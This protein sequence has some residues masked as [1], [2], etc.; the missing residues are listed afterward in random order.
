MSNQTKV[1]HFNFS[2]RLPWP[3]V[4][5]SAN[6]DFQFRSR[7][8]APSTGSS[9]RITPLPLL[10]ANS[11]PS[12]RVWGMLLD[13]RY[14]ENP[15]TET[16]FNWLILFPHRSCNEST[17][18]VANRLRVTTWLSTTAPLSTML[19]ERALERRSCTPLLEGRKTQ[20]FACLARC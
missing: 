11:L 18:M 1:C 3:M 6:R 14:V 19:L 4:W 16:Q 15:N 13:I 12:S 8:P 17:S 5:H 20:T 2:P 7:P 10:S 9:L